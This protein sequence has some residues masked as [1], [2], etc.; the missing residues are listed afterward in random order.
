[1]DCIT[2]LNL[3]LLTITDLEFSH[4]DESLSIV[5]LSII[6]YIGQGVQDRCVEREGGESQT[7]Q[8]L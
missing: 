1:V 2:V 6:S 8:A 5:P 7:C 4:Q 3:L